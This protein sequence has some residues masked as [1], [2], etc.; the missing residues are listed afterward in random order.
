MAMQTSEKHI[1][2]R[3]GSAM[4][5]L[6]TIERR[7]SAASESPKLATRLIED[8][9]KLSGELERAFSDV[10]ELLVHCAQLQ[11]S[12]S[13]SSRRAQM[14]FDLAPVPCVITDLAGAIVDANA[15]AVDMLN[16]SRRHLIGRSFH[17]YLSSDRE[18]FLKRIQQ[19]SRGPEAEQWEAKLRPR[20]RS[21][22]EAGLTAALDPDGRVLLMIEPRVVAAKSLAL[23]AALE[24][25]GQDHAGAQM[26][27]SES[28]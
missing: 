20:E 22:V 25:V 6:A 3:L 7:A 17:L 14:L 1:Q 27:A 4:Y 18:V 19:L 21:T 2:D 9:R 13:A 16:V 15:P 24:H 28:H 26:M 10:H 12:A 11:D 5:R 8:V 23:A